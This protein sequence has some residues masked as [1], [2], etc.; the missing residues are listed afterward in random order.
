MEEV[1]SEDEGNFLTVEHLKP[2][3][4]KGDNSEQNLM[5]CCYECNIARGVKSIRAFCTAYS[6]PLSSVRDRIKARRE[7]HLD[8]FRLAA[9]ILLGRSKNMGV[10]QPAEFVIRHD[11]RVKRQWGSSIDAEYWQHLQSQRHLFCEKCTAP[12]DKSTGVYTPPKH[13]LAGTEAS[14]LSS[15]KEADW[16]LSDDE[17]LF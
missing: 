11:W 9:M 10:L 8:H 14:A 16:F 1:L 3:S 5:T 2:V 6:Y 7:R 12:V 4:K 17:M 15:L 13:A